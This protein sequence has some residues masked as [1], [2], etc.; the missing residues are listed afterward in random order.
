MGCD[1]MTNGGPAATMST[2]EIAD[3]TGKRHDN[4]LADARK[5]LA[6]L[7]GDGGVLHFEDTHQNPQNGQSYPALRLPKLRRSHHA[8]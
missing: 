3:L 5:M 8:G 1:L 4:V 6:E 7:H 2:R